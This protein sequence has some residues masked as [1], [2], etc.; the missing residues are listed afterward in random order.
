M[1]QANQSSGYPWL[2]YLFRLGHMTQARPIATLPAIFVT[3]MGKETL[4]SVWCCWVRRI[5][6]WT[7]QQLSLLGARGHPAL[8]WSQYWGK[9]RKQG[10][11]GCV[12]GGQKQRVRDIGRQRGTGCVL[13]RNS[14]LCIQ[15][16]PKWAIFHELA[17]YGDRYFPPLCF[18]PSVCLSGVSLLYNWTSPECI[19]IYMKPS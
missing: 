3:A 2:L 17:S 12:G 10:R 11:G 8:E 7:G 13:W 9:Q 19:H 16:C 1:T 15:P 14:K 18:L 5:S 6:A 4:S